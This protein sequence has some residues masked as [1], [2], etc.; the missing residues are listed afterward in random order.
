ML[1][2]LSLTSSHVPDPAHRPDEPE[3]PPENAGP[4]PTHDGNGKLSP[5]LEQYIEIKA[6]N[7]DSLLFYRMG[8]F[9]ELFFEDAEVASRALGIVLTKRGKHQ[10]QDIPMCGVPVHRSDEYLHRLI[11]LGHRVAVCEQLEDPA[12]AKKRGYKSVVRRDVVRLVTPGTLTEDTLLDA[13]RNNYLLAVA[14]ARLS[15]VDSEARFGL[16]WID[17]STGEFRIT[18]CDRVM[19]AAEIARLEPGEILV[20]DA[21]VCRR[22]TGAAVARIAGGNAADA[23][24]V[25]RSPPPSG[26]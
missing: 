25:R 19:L 21:L 10:G 22:R 20:S 1:N 26:G 4:T 18:E 11:A 15:S 7:P 2:L 8:D 13:E 24:R 3:T 9:Y 12:E 23:R 16:A 6:A 5:M 17:I 14:R